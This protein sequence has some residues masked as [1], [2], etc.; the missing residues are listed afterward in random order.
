MRCN[1]S[2]TSKKV[3]STRLTMIRKALFTLSWSMT[4]ELREARALLASS[5]SRLERSREVITSCLTNSKCVAWCTFLLA[6]ASSSNS[7]LVKYSVTISLIWRFVLAKLSWFS[8]YK[9]AFSIAAASL[10]S[11]Y[12]PAVACPKKSDRCFL[13]SGKSI[14]NSSRLLKSFLKLWA[15]WFGVSILF[16]C[17]P[18][19]KWLTFIL[20]SSFLSRTDL[21]KMAGSSWWN[22]GKSIS[23]R[24][25]QNS[26]TSS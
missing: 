6:V 13:A 22:K 25:L 19:N 26:A 15:T 8:R 24:Q 2:G 23:F 12:P 5:R 10:P 21:I 9:T 18:A 16:L 11:K 7:S 1:M 20:S 4:E 3:S 17:N 14:S